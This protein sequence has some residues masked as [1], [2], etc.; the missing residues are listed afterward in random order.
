MCLYYDIVDRQKLYQIKY[1]ISASPLTSIVIIEINIA[2]GHL[3]KVW[4]R[5]R[6]AHTN[7]KTCDYSKDEFF[8]NFFAWSV[9]G[10]K[11]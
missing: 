8:V 2:V 1:T 7:E 6:K 11:N 9:N 3:H 10:T 4:I 5:V